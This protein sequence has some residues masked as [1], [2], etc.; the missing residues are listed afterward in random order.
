MSHVIS[1]NVGQ[2]LADEGGCPMGTGVGDDLL[3]HARV[4]LRLF[5]VAHDQRP[6]D[7]ASHAEYVVGVD[8]QSRIERRSGSHELGD[9]QRRLV[10]L[11]LTDRV[12]HRGRVHTV[13]ES[14]DKSE[15]S[16]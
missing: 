4:P 3:I 1:S 13:S 16:H 8:E 6:V 11:V 9:H 2:E 15:V 7:R 10:R 12:L 14:G 5:L